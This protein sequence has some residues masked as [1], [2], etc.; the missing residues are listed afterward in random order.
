MVLQNVFQKLGRFNVPFNIILAYYEIPIASLAYTELLYY[1]I[2]VT[3]T[4]EWKE[5]VIHPVGAPTGATDMFFSFSF[6]PFA[7]YQTIVLKC[8]VD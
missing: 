4:K 3:V 6:L 7:F 8:Q 2:I 1:S 5:N